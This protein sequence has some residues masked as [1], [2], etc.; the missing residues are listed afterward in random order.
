MLK[1]VE[2]EQ[3]LYEHYYKYIKKL[4]EII[5]IIE[6]QENFFFENFQVIK[7]N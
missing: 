2:N 3:I 4:M 7:L 5:N 1:N 6:N